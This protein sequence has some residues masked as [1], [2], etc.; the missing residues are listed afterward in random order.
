MAREDV[1]ARGREAAELGMRDACTITRVTSQSTNPD[2]AVVTDTSETVYEGICRMQQPPAIARPDTVGAALV[3]QQPFQ[4]QL[5]MVGSEG[6]E[7]GD[8]AT[9]TVSID[10]DLVG[11]SFW[12]KALFHKTDATARRLGLE[13]VTS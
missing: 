3:Y 6:V 13:E 1:L 5:P 2:N 12:V 11:R 7:V 8:R 10:A 4:L 9:V